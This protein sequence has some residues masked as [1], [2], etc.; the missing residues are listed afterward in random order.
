MKYN[1]DKKNNHEGAIALLL[2]IMITA[3]T[4]VSAVIVSMTNI[5]DLM[6]SYHFSEA[7][8]ADVDLDA[9]LEDAML[10]LA[11]TTAASGTYYLNSVGSNCYYE[12]SSIISSGL[13][14]VT[15]TASSTSGLGY[16]QDTVVVQVNVSST[17]ISIY[18]Y[19]NSTISFDSLLYCG[20]ATCAGTETCS[21][22]SAD[23][24]SCAVCGNGIV[25]GAEVCDDDNTNDETQTCGNLIVEGA[26]GGPYCNWNCSAAIVL[27][28]TCD[29]GG[30]SC[31]D[32]TKQS[33]TFC[34]DT[35]TAVDK[36]VSEVCDY[37]GVAC[38]A[39]EATFESGVQ[40]CTLKNPKCT[41]GCGSC[42][43]YCL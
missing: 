11:S 12:I 10:R 14:T 6:S 39:M 5:S 34:N 24:G 31:G 23:C 22:C 43:N 4:V 9:C 13:K 36:V 25:E 21:N 42:T 29:D 26:A 18:A 16:W 28:E 17:P 33:G 20:D 40:G 27:T 8:Q 30:E 3:L 32:G 37:T 7:Q 35:C 19:K 15:S 1:L 2:V 41:I 38:G